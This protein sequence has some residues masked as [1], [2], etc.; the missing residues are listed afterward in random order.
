MGGAAALLQ[1]ELGSWGAGRRRWALPEE[2]PEARG[3]DAMEG[4]EGEGV[5]GCGSGCWSRP[6]AVAGPWTPV[7]GRQGQVP[8]GGRRGVPGGPGGRAGGSPGVTRSSGPAGSRLG[9]SSAEVP[10]PEP[11]L[12]LAHACESLPTIVWY[13]LTPTVLLVITASGQISFSLQSGPSV[14]VHRLPT[15]SVC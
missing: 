3:G 11:D 10:H 4:L 9:L 7:P 13:S 12:P 5:K 15:S 14:N 8:S 6:G 1:P 2:C